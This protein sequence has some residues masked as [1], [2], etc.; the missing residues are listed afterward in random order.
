MDRS[1]AVIRRY[2]QEWVD[3]GRFPRHDGRDRPK[4]TADVEDRLIVRS[5][6]TTLDSSLSTIR[7]TTRTLVSTVIIH[8]EI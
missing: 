7:R 8:S 5:A 3:S 1:D 2:W 4:A 6:V